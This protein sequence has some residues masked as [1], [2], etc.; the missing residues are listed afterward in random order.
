MRCIVKDEDMDVGEIGVVMQY[1]YMPYI[2]K[3]ALTG[4][5][6]NLGINQFKNFVPVSQNRLEL[7]PTKHD[8]SKGNYIV[9]CR[10]SEEVEQLYDMCGALMSN[11]GPCD[12]K[13]ID[14]KTE[15]SGSHQM[16]TYYYPNYTFIEAS[17]MF[18]G[19]KM[20][21]PGSIRPLTKEEPIKQS[22]IKKTMKTLNNWQKKNF[23]GDT[24][25]MLEMGYV[26]DDLSPTEAGY[27]LNRDK[28]F[29]D[30]F[31]E[32]AAIAKKE[33]EELKAANKN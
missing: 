10:T 33:R 23:D 9:T 24:K 18:G 4:K 29:T 1:D 5:E 22:L 7:I 13:V 28:Q 32:L 17:E 2:K 11:Y 14:G 15:Q 20:P 8:L 31:K 3:S 27:Q 19:D 21:E 25:A 30:A 12:Y 16:M 26:N 6:Q